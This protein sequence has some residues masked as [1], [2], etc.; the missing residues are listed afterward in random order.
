MK[1]F[2]LVLVWLIS[3]WFTSFI[4]VAKAQAQAFGRHF[5]FE[6]LSKDQGLKANMPNTL[7]ASDT[8]IYQALKWVSN[9][10]DEAGLGRKPVSP[11]LLGI[12]LNSNLTNYFTPPIKSMSKYFK[13]YI[14]SDESEVVV[15]AA[16]INSDN[17]EDYQY[18]VVENDS[19]ELVSWSK[20]VRLEQ[21]YGAKQP[22][23]FI[24]KF[25]ALN[26]QLLIEVKNINDYSIREGVI[27]DWRKSFR[28]IVTQMLISTPQTDQK[29]L[30]FFNILSTQDNRGFANKF[31][32]KTKLPIDLR[33]GLDSVTSVI[34][35]FKDH[36]SISY[37]VF[38]LK[39]GLF[40]ND[41]TLVSS[42][43]TDNDVDIDSKYFDKSGDYEFIIQR[44]GS[45]KQW[46]EEQIL[47]IPFKIIQPPKII[48]KKVSIRQLFPYIFTALGGVVICVFIYYRHNKS[49]LQKAA[50]AQQLAILKLKS[51]RAQLN[52]HFMFNALTSIQNLINKN[53]IQDANFYLSKFAGL[54]RQVLDSNNENLL[55][56]ED[57]I[58]LLTDYLEMEQLRFNFKF[59]LIVDPTLNL[60]NIEVPAML[61]QPFVENA[62]KHGVSGLKEDGIIQILFKRVQ[63]DLEMIV[64]DN[65]NGFDTQISSNG[66]GI[67]L[68]EER[69]EL[70][71]QL[72]KEQSIS[73]TYNSTK[74]G[75]LVILRLSNWVS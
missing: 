71:N 72:F 61:L 20:I 42:L 19:V 62:V 13:G 57:E 66:Y 21:N 5:A 29:R 33:F 46:P 51:I 27:F 54:T 58:K 55:S 31:D 30:N 2:K 63:T 43:I 12:K 3:C 37:D 14:I 6:F 34:F 38:L 44:V 53:N 36:T 74:T 70:L 56:L 60:P 52:P 18:R 23:G 28:P 65:G 9:P 68:S 26:K 69:V 8:A 64:Q 45:F 35:Y 59:D 41:T 47:R 15:I 49:K 39:R 50:N 17:Y 48:D 11:I 7:L 67:K 10:I 16:G 4:L 32:P 75:T 73:L 40:H 24:G 25:K 1:I 22:Y